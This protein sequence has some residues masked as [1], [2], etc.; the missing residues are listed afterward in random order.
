MLCHYGTQVKAYETFVTRHGIHSNKF[1]HLWNQVL[2][3]CETNSHSLCEVLSAEAL[4]SMDELGR[5]Y[6]LNVSSPHTH[7]NCTISAVGPTSHKKF[8]RNRNLN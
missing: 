1:L 5:T 2:F 4:A 7:D 8:S 6:L 3:V